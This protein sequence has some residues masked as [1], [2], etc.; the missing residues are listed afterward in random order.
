MKTVTLSKLK[1][2]DKCIVVRIGGSGLTR[3]RILD[4]GV[5]KGTK[6]EVIRTAPL[7]DPIE[8]VLRDYNLT[9]RK[10]EADKV[11]VSLINQ[12]EEAK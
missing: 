6:I 12:S 9:L 7:G 8:F 10:A 11:Y 3:R 1:A 2:G 4:M 5:V